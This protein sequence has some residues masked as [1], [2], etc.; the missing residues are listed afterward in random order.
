MGTTTPTSRELLECLGA[1]SEDLAIELL[2]N[3]SKDELPHLSKSV[4]RLIISADLLKRGGLE[5]PFPV[6]EVIRHYAVKQDS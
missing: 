5:T 3:F 4:D 1:V 2:G 6:L